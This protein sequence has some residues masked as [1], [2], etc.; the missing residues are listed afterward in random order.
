[1]SDTPGCRRGLYVA[2]SS[3][4]LVP[5]DVYDGAGASVVGACFPNANS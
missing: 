3:G 4:L 5:E 1:M 2:F